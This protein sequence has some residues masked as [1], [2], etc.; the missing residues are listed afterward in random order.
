MP[1]RV[2]A[3][4]REPKNRGPRKAKSDIA[5]AP[6]RLPRR[7]NAAREVFLAS[8]S[9]DGAEKRGVAV[10]GLA[11]DQGE[12]VK[13]CNGIR[14]L[15]VV[16]NKAYGS[17]ALQPM[18]VFS[19]ADNVEQ[20]KVRIDDKISRLCRGHALPDESLEQTVDDLMGYLVLLKIA[21]LR[22]RNLGARL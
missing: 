17:S 1:P 2:P 5:P 14:D 6:F 16:K 8:D 13:V 10:A 20:L 19:R 11:Q 12:I 7:G 4:K 21:V 22:R 3:K 9:D 15:L 18:R